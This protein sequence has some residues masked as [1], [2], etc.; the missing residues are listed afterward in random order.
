MGPLSVFDQLS[1]GALNHLL[2]Q[3]DW[4]RV[5]LAPF[6]GMHARLAMP[7][8]QLELAVREDGYFEEA[9][10]AEPDVTMTLPAHAPLL[11]LQGQD[12]VIAAARVEGNAQFATELSF[13][14]RELRWE[15]EEDLSRL[16]GDIAAH[17]LVQ[18]GKGLAAWQQDAGTRLAE[19]M[20]EYAAEEGR[21]LVRAPDIADFG[22]AVGELNDNVALLEKRLEKLV[23]TA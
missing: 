14:L 11:A 8:W 16:V 9:A 12:K 3:A 20:A 2:K 5:R 13:V 4:A 1:L 15:A 19:N 10:G 22:K 17:R 7:P 6:A 23:I 21:L 18:G